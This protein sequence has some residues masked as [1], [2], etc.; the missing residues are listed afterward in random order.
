MTTET[1]MHDFGWAIKQLKAGEKSARKSWPVH[2]RL[3]LEAGYVR[4]RTQSY[5]DKVNSGDM[6]AE[7]WVEY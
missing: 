7:D 5:T 4:V 2:W 6:L 1:E 3:I